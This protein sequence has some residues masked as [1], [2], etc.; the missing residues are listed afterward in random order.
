MSPLARWFQLNAHQPLAVLKA[1]AR[2]NGHTDAAIAAA[3]AEYHLS[4]EA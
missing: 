3:L 4:G 1:L 2:A